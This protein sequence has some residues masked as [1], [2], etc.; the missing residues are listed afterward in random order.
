MARTWEWSG[1]RASFAMGIAGAVN[2]QQLVGSAA[3]GKGH[4]V[5]RIIGNATVQKSV[6]SVGIPVFGFGVMVLNE[7]V[8]ALPDPTVDHDAPWIWHQ[9]GM[10]PAFD[11]GGDFSVVRFGIDVHGMRKVPGDSAI[12]WILSSDGAVALT[13]TIGIRIG[14]KLP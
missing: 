10:L 3:L 8:T 2:G 13:Y 11:S 4:T 14:L 12:F 1:A 5:A 7:G 6:V 9:M